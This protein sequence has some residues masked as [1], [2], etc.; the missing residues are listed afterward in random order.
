MTTLERTAPVPAPTGIWQRIRRT[1]QAWIRDRPQ[2]YHL[3]SV[4]R[5]PDRDLKDI[6]LTRM[7]IDH[8]LSKP[9]D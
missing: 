9:F 8:M 7:D 4:L 3:E 5:L 1:L 6:G 2:Q